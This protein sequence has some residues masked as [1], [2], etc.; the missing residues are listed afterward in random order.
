[1]VIAVV[2]GISAQ[3]L[4]AYL[5][6]SSI[7]FLLLFGIL[8]GSD[9]IGLLHTHALGTGL[10]VI[11]ALGTAVILFEGGLNLDWREVK[12]SSSLQL[13]V[14]LGALVTL[15]GGSMAAH[16]LAEFPWPIA[17]LYASLVVVTGPTVISP[18]MKQ[19][20]VDKQV[21]TLLEGEGVL[22]D[23]VGAV[24][25]FV[26]LDTI[27]NGDTDPINALIGMFV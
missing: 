13:L 3:V 24:L 22:I 9:G 10:E 1:M 17:F 14:S 11:V 16:Y 21:A 25:A 27:L 6:V 20:N 23:P 12:V 5:K 8:L 2:A 7:V 15:L 19:I 4:A 26:V 18:L